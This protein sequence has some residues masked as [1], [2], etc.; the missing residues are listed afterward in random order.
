MSHQSLTSLIKLSM[1]LV[2]SNE[3]ISPMT[4]V[5]KK[6]QPLEHATQEAPQNSFLRR[7]EKIKRRRGTELR[8]ERKPVV[9]SYHL[10][11]REHD[12]GLCQNNYLLA[13]FFHKDKSVLFDWIPVNLYYL[14]NL[15][16]KERQN[17]SR[18]TTF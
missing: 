2:L 11:V 16:Y 10:S 9:P 1:V 15:S 12:C 18:I 5:P 6:R 8:G 14:V 7:Q 13:V 3:K 17:S 4:I